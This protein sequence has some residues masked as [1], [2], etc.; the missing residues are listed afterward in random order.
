MA[1]VLSKPFC[2]P[3]SVR[4]IGITRM[5]HNSHITWYTGDMK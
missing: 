3:G 4:V 2:M 1:L 5:A